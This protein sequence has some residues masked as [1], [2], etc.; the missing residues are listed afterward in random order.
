MQKRFLGNTG[1]EVSEIAFGCVE[2]GMPYG[3]G[4]ESEKDMLSQNEAVKLLNEALDN[5]I[6]FFDTARAYGNS[7]KLIGNAFKN[8]RDDV[9]ICSKCRDFRNNHGDLPG[10]SKLQELVEQSF[11]ESLA[12]LQ[13][14]YLDV[15]MLHQVDEEILGTEE[16]ANVFL[17]LK[18]D[19]KIRA[20]GV[21]TYTLEETEKAI[22]LGCWDVI[23]LPFNLLD[24][25]QREFFK[26]A[27]EKGIGIVVRSVLSKGLLSHRG[28]HL[29]PAL[30]NVEEQ[31]KK[32]EDYIEDR[33]YDLPEFATRFVLSH[34]EISS[35]LVGIDK[36]VYLEQALSYA[37]GE[38]MDLRE[39]DRI[40]QL[41]YP[42]P[43][44]INLA[45]WSK[46]NW[47]K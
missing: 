28:K 27:K 32:I 44:F 14:D 24:Q 6:N 33:T 25:S 39:L 15:F 36:R 46:M 23:Q 5:G 20:T 4:I 41:S 37:E 31:I 21:S 18:S 38:Y 11:A 42:E 13:T 29:H 35:A 2:I 10:Q 17:K 3:I 9:V 43:A 45:Y 26:P 47:L 19:G 40:K 34:P 30:K 8:K 12:F 22:E 1:I 7:E 16:I